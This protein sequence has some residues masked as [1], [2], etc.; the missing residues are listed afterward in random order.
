MQLI[1]D[2]LNAIAADPDARTYWVDPLLG[3][4]N[5]DLAAEARFPRYSLDLDRTAVN[6]RHLDLEQ[7]LQHALVAAGYN[8]LRPF[9]GAADAEHVNLDP[10]PFTVPLG[11]HLLVIRQDGLRPPQ[12]QSDGAHSVGLFNDAGYDVAFMLQELLIEQFPLCFPQPL[13]HHLLGGLRGDTAGVVGQRLLGGH[14]VPHSCGGL[15]VLSVFQADFTVGVFYRFHHGFE[16]INVD[17][18]GVGVQLDGDVLPRRR[19]VFFE[20]GRQGH[21]NRLQ[22]LFSGQVTLRGQLSQRY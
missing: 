21:F 16:S 10:L 5:G 6:L 7:P 9:R 20:R 11:G 4:V 2:A 13:E 22:H 8:D 12:V 19:V 18:P 3:G 1:D 15:D 17:L 14:L